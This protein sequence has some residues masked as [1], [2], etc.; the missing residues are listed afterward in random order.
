MFL[1]ALMLCILLLTRSG[2]CWGRVGRHA[3][4]DPFLLPL[5]LQ[6]LLLMIENPT[7]ELQSIPVQ[8][9]LDEIQG[10]DANGDG[11]ITRTELEWSSELVGENTYLGKDAKKSSI[12]G[13]V[14]FER[15]KCY[16]ALY[17]VHD[18]SVPCVQ[19]QV[20]LSCP[21]RANPYKAASGIIYDFHQAFVCLC[22]ILIE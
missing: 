18:M 3:L 7:K 16:W 6:N 12:K 4:Q 8:Q 15:R 2:V 19:A 17:M 22:K 13:F 5:G 21:W 14:D 20:F 1:R 9:L 11:M 10:L